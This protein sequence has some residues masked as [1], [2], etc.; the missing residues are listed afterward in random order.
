MTTN[1]TEHAKARWA[2]AAKS[3]GTDGVSVGSLL[4]AMAES[5]GQLRPQMIAQRRD[6][7][8][9]ALE[10]DEERRARPGPR[11][12]QDDNEE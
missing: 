12:K 9:R 5:T 11:R 10:I 7:S 2:D 1:L 3:I 4:Q 6:I 8:A